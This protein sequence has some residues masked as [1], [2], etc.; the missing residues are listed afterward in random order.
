MH[1]APSTKKAKSLTVWKQ[2]L[3]RKHADL[4]EAIG[5]EVK[6]PMPDFLEIQTLKR[7]R[8]QVK[9]DLALI[10]GVLRT[11]GTAAEVRPA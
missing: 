9:E 6:R 10:E 1:H 11:V 4:E 2:S 3:E 8:L 5:E 7:R